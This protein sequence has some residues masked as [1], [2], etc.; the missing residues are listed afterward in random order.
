M[1]YVYDRDTGRIRGVAGNQV[2]IE[3]FMANW[4]NVDYVD[5]KQNPPKKVFEYHIDLATKQLVKNT[6]P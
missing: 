5:L 4:T 6:T 2:K 3:R 1:I